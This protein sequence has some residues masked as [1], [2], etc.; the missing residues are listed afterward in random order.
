LC[1]GRAERRRDCYWAIY[2][3]WPLLSELSMS[4]GSAQPKVTYEKLAQCQL[5]LLKEA[6]KHYSNGDP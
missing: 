2:Y 4:F 5:Q 1:E 6:I 3:Y